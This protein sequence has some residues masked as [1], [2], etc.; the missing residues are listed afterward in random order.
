MLL[1]RRPGGAVRSRSKLGPRSNE[2]SGWAGPG[3]SR[4]VPAPAPPRRAQVRGAVPTAPSASHS[5]S[6]I[7][8]PSH[9]ITRSRATASWFVPLTIARPSSKRVIS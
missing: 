2:M 4:S 6:G 8:I 7:G 3:H 5:G 1:R 9:F